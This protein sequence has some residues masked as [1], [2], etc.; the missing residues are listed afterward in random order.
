MQNQPEPQLP[1]SNEGK[2]TEFPFE[3]SESASSSS[4]SSSS[5]KVSDTFKQSIEN[6]DVL[7]QWTKSAYKCTRQMVS[8][9]LGKSQRTVLDPE[10]DASIE[11]LRDMK[12][13]YELVLT[14][15]QRMTAQFK[16]IVETQKA[17][18]NLFAELGQK[19]SDL[20]DEF[21]GNAELQKS[22]VQNAEILI[23]GL[24]LFTSNL[25]T[26]C[27]KAMEDMLCT[28]QKY[29]ASRLEYDA[30]RTELD[31]L[32]GDCVPTTID[33]NNNTQKNGDGMKKK[34]DQIERMER[35]LTKMRDQMNEWREVVSIKMRFLEDNRATSMRKQLV[36]FQ[37]IMNSYFVTGS[38]GQVQEQP[39]KSL[40]KLQSSVAQQLDSSFPNN[41]NSKSNDN[42]NNNSVSNA[43]SKDDANS[44]AALE[45]KFVDFETLVSS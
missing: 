45:L 36:L 24:K 16:Q 38:Q 26:L 19:A 22:L 2:L 6:L 5:H 21:T 12:K 32:R 41:S 7:R 9:K 31:K 17:L 8:E 4:S 39:Q 18:G 30:T 23:D 42:S 29:E 1:K 13:K 11:T 28:V 33:T 44:K 40:V 35:E 43:N 25:E 20:N 27:S 10:L 3:S 15:A 37:T 34:A 14:C